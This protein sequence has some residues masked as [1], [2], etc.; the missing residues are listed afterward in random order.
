M[1]VIERGK[2]IKHHNNKHLFT[3]SQVIY[4]TDK[5]ASVMY[6]P[7]EVHVEC[8]NLFTNWTD[9]MPDYYFKQKVE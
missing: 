2:E 4:L 3:R 9:I 1:H 5:S 7:S 6:F 8:L